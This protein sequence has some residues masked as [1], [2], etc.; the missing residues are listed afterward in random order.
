MSIYLNTGHSNLGPYLSPATL[1]A[2]APGSEKYSG[3]TRFADEPTSY[4]GAATT[5]ALGTTAGMDSAGVA[6]PAYGTSSI[7]QRTEQAA[8][9]EAAVTGR[10]AAAETVTTAVAAPAAKTTQGQPTVCKQEFYTEVSQPWG[11]LVLVMAWRL[12]VRQF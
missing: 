6:S 7:E 5:P 9:E 4:S 12:P 8:V 3:S 1:Q 11:A 10:P 2:F